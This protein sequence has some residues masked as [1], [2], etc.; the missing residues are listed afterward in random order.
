MPTNPSKRATYARQ[1]V[2]QQPRCGLAL[3]SVVEQLQ[4]D[5]HRNR[6]LAPLVS[7]PLDCQPLN[8]SPV[9]GIGI[10]VGVG[11]GRH[12]LGLNDIGQPP[13]PPPL[14]LSPPSRMIKIINTTSPPQ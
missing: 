12:D 13:L 14:I 3:D 7:I 9:I 2:K 10:R 8:A 11:T 5:H 1:S 6:A 4:L